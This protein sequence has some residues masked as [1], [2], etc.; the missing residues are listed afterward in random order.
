MSNVIDPHSFFGYVYW[1]LWQM[2]GCNTKSYQQ[3]R[4][5]KV[6]LPA[7][8]NAGILLIASFRFVSSKNFCKFSFPNPSCRSPQRFLF[9]LISPVGRGWV[10]WLIRQWKH[11]WSSSNGEQNMWKHKTDEKVC[12][13]ILFA[14]RKA[15]GG[16]TAHWLRWNFFGAHLPNLLLGRSPIFFFNFW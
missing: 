14:G 11:L 12:S 8:C 1:A 10:G 5:A 3:W 7:S 16:I 13:I 6:L 4:L 9:V 2:Y 15:P